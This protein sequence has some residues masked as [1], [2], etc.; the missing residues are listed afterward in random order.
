MID[1]IVMRG[2]GQEKRERKILNPTGKVFGQI[3][4]SPPTA[5]ICYEAEGKDQEQSK[6]YSFLFSLPLPK[7]D[8]GVTEWTVQ[9]GRTC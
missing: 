3:T 9:G 8:P 7:A 4:S 5:Q 6:R 2:P 1:A